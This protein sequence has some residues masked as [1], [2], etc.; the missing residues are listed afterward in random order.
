MRRKRIKRLFTTVGILA[1]LALVLTASYQVYL[2]A[3][4]PLEHEEVVTAYAEQFELPPSLIYAVIQTESHFREDAVSSAGAKGLMQ[5]MDGTYEWIQTKL[6]GDPEP[7]DR[8][9][10]P[11]VNIR[12]GCKL[13]SVLYGQFDNTET[14]LAAY[15]AG[16]GTVQGWLA[17]GQYSADGVT[18]SYIP[19]EETN[20]YVKRVLRAQ[21]RYRALYDIK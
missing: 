1:V 2:R 8:I 11:E 7:A 16:I 6:P 17:D 18:L 15:N 3:V 14:V 12:C 9:F 20:T 10:E 13:L 19:I 5:L 4:Y 21:A